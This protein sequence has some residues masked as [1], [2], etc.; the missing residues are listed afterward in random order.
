MDGKQVPDPPQPPPQSSRKKRRLRGGSFNDTLIP[1]EKLAERD[2]TEEK[3][4]PWHLAQI[5][6]P[7]DVVFQVNGPYKYDFDDSLGQG[8]TIFIIDDGFVDIPSVRISF[9]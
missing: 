3:D 5:S 7:K 6:V 2:A 9:L 1:W 8:Q 4:S